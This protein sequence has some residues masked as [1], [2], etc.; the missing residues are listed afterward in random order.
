[1]PE[2]QVQHPPTTPKATSDTGKTLGRGGKPRGPR[3]VRGRDLALVLP[4]AL[5]FPF[6][7]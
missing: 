2:Q 3:T 4:R 7:L 5:G 6:S 1:M